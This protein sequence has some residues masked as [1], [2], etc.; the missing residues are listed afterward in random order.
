[1]DQKTYLNWTLGQKEEESIRVIQTAVTNF[2]TD[3]VV[4]WFSG[5]KDSTVLLDLTRTALKNT[6]PVPVLT[7]DISDMFQEVYDFRDRIAKEWHLDLRVARKEEVLKAIKV[8][9]DKESCPEVLQREACKVSVAQNGWDAIITPSRW[10]ENETKVH[11]SYFYHPEGLSYT[12]VNPL[13][14]FYEI[15]IWSYIRKHNVPYCE[16]Y[17]RGYRSLYRKSSDEKSEE[18]VR[19]RLKDLGYL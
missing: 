6:L 8:D 17:D 11:K 15:D 10:D 2:G 9:K 5:E 16:L 14:H 13:L 1:V 12:E 19:Q 3:K 18:V 7:T 4:I